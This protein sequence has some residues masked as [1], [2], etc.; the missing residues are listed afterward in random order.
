MSWIQLTSNEDK[1]INFVK[2]MNDGG[3]LE[4][5]FVQRVPDYFIAYLSSHSGC[6]KSC[7]FCHLTSTKQ[8]MM[9]S[10]TF[11]DYLDQSSQIINYYKGLL[12]EE[13]V[14]TEKIINFNFMARGEPLTNPVVLENSRALFDAL[15]DQVKPLNLTPQFMISSIIPD[16]FN[17]K[18]S[19]IFSDTRSTLYYSLYSTDEKFRKRWLPK[20]MNCFS[21]LDK[22]ADFQAETGR[23]IALHWAFI[24]GENDNVEKLHKT[25]KDVKEHGVKAR[26]NLVRYNPYSD[27]YG[28]EPTENEIKELFDIIKSYIPESNSRIVPRVGRD[29]KASCGMFIDCKNI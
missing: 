16:D 7:R 4:T 12:S 13:R 27:R 21:A 25:M 24:E 18:L 8:T 29:V 11:R 22:I 9:S 14:Q 28:V 3:F 6:N 5:R 20:A 2:S 19:S 1:S 15:H 23:E 26:F 17:K 10:S